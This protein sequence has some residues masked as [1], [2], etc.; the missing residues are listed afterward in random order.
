MGFRMLPKRI[1]I[2]FIPQFTMP[3]STYTIL[4]NS[5]IQG[6]DVADETGAGKRSGITNVNSST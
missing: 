5:S 4:V 6:M 1:P 2:S 3:P